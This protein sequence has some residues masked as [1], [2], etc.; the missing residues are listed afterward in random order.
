LTSGANRVTIQTTKNTSDAARAAFEVFCLT[1]V[2]PTDTTGVHGNNG[3]KSAGKHLFPSGKGRK[4]LETSGDWYSGFLWDSVEKRRILTGWNLEKSLILCALSAFELYSNL[5][6]NKRSTTVVT[7]HFIFLIM[8]KICTT[9]TRIYHPCTKPSL[10]ECK[11]MKNQNH[12]LNW[13]FA[14]PL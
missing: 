1:T 3:G 12:Q 9:L 4:C 2:Y 7:L 14:Q 6:S 13:W 11:G 5:S 10:D 8:A